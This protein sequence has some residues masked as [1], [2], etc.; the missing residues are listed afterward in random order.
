MMTVDDRTGIVFEIQGHTLVPRFILAD[1]D[2]Q[3]GKGASASNVVWSPSFMLSHAPSLL[4]GTL[5][6]V[7]KAEWMAVK[8]RQ[9][10]V[11][12]I[13]RDWTSGKGTG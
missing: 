4:S 1:G 12:S 9:L 5:V 13:G 2:G 3:T 11:G 8:D 7:M 10:Y 6:V